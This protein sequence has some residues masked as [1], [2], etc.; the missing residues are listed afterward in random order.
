[1]LGIAGISIASKDKASIFKMFPWLLVL[2]IAAFALFLADEVAF[3]PAFIMATGISSLLE[4]LLIMYF[5]ILTSKGYVTPAVA[6]AFSGA[7]VRAGIA[8]GNT[9]AVATS[10]PPSW[11]SPSRPR[12]A[13]GSC[14]CWPCCWCR[15]CARSSTSWH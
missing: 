12:R 9:W 1:M 11:P 6:F 3:F 8:V 15:W 13:W 7:F 10:T 14:A 4:I 2:L 5:G